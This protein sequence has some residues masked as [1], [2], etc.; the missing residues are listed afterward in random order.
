MC[1]LFMCFFGEL[2]RIIREDIMRETLCGGYG[3]GGVKSGCRTEDTPGMYVPLIVSFGIRLM[4]E[5]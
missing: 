4:S 2:A 1:G 5:C 3:G